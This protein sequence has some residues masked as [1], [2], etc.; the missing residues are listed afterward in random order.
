MDVDDLTMIADGLERILIDAPLEIIDQTGGVGEAAEALWT[1]LEESGF[2]SLCVTEEHGGAGAGLE[3]VAMLARLGANRALALPM[4]DT[5]LARGLLS[6]T[7][8]VP[9]AR[10][11]ALRDL[12]DPAMPIA[13]AAQCDAVLSF[14]DGHL[15][16]LAIEPSTLRP[17]HGAEDGAAHF[18]SQPTREIA[19]IAAPDWLTADSFRAL[20]AYARSASMS[21]A[22]QATLDL[23]LAYT[24]E[25]EQFGRP[26]ARFQ[27][28]QHHLADIACETA[29]A[30]AAVEM[31]SD[32][33]AADPFCRSAT[34]DEIAIAK[35][36][37]GEAAN[38]VT[39]AAHQAHGAMGFTREY[40]L[41]RFTRRL[42][43]WQ[44]EFGTAQEWAQR[45]GHTILSGQSPSLWPA[46]TRAG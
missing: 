2:L 28:I 7:G 10:R 32:A 19:A 43:Q 8:I 34:L 36:R 38:R 12:I 27:A 39:A 44:D 24:S 1:T 46:I 35:T 14:D 15:Q 21:G 37:C 40:S 33:L 4:V 23:T 30:S 42:W 26:L 6:T 11:I 25:R 45:L 13:H 22:M 18:A 20:A 16:L 9:P 17:A 29:A 41:G 5:A 3:A 31:A